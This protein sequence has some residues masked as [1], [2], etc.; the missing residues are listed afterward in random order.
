MKKF[1]H[2][3]LEKQQASDHVDKSQ[4]RDDIPMNEVKTV[5]PTISGE[6]IAGGNSY[7]VKKNARSTNARSINANGHHPKRFEWKDITFH[8]GSLKE[9]RFTMTISSLLQQTLVMQT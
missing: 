2:K 6:L 7:S 4:D 1:I 9:L 3:D 8:C 5:I